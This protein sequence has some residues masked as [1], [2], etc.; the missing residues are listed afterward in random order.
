MFKINNV[1]T[2]VKILVAVLI[3]IIALIVV[4][5]ISAN[6][7]GKLSNNMIKQL[8]EQVYMVNYWLLN[9][10]RD[11]YQALESY[12]N[13]QKGNFNEEYI[14]AQVDGYNENAGQTRERVDNARKIV[15]EYTEDFAGLTHET[16]KLSIIE[17]FD[18]FDKDFSEWISLYDPQTNKVTDPDEYLTRFGSA[19]D[20]INQ[21]EEIIEVYSETTIEN[22]K[23]A[24]KSAALVS[25]YISIIAI[26][27]SIALGAFILINIY[28]RTKMA[29]AL[30]Q[31]TSRFDLVHDKSFDRYI[32]EKDE[33][34]DIINAEMKARN[35]FRSIIHNV[36]SETS[37]LR[38]T[39]ISTNDNIS[40]L[41]GSVEDVSATTE[42]LSAGMEETAASTQEMNATS[43][44][45]ERAVETIAEKAQDGAVTA[46]EINM[47]AEGLHKSFTASYNNTNTIFEGVKARLE[48]TLEESKAV[49]QINVLAESILQITSQTNLLALNA[50]IEA[51]RAGEAGRGFAVVA[52]EIRKLAEDSKMAV[53]KIQQAAQTVIASVDN[54]AAE[55]NTLLNFVSKDVTR[56]YR[57]M[58]EGTDQ[59]NK[60]AEKVNDL[61]TDFSATSE[62]LLASIHNMMKAIVEVTQAT[63][64]GAAGT[65]NIA[66][67]AGEIVHKASLV[68]DEIGTVRET[69]DKLELT[70]AKFR[71]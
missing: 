44:E 61:V 68:N 64:E 25:I 65:T 40:S 46:K 16:S 48:K 36:V 51:A 6:S 71:I 19:R 20:R 45:I 67:K 55:S 66:E 9:A 4:T 47:R 52:D 58:L 60:D 24:A 31:K 57:T 63:N 35:E 69:A 41:R 56:D 21:I 49:E 37:D 53:V 50:A 28:R 26:L 18:L 14:K 29:V 13:L 39:V 23:K 62:Q 7:M 38:K 59:Y 15:E 3:P 1:K 54:L 33:F 5:F 8:H 27:I 2:G 30:I 32:T 70:V 10:D 43:S 42:E 22:S 12:L 17:L 34:A 11:Y